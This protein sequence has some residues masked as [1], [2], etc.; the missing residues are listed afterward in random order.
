MKVFLKKLKADISKTKF[1]FCIN[2]GTTEALFDVNILIQRCLDKNVDLHLYF[3]D[4]EKAFDKTKHQRFLEFIQQK[5][6]D[7]NS[8]RIIK[9]LYWNQKQQ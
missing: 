2:L 1:E 5:V 3:I 4:Y 9:Y 6:C 8:I 7:L